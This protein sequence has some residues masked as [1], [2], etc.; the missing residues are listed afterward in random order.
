[1]SAHKIYFSSFLL[2][3]SDSGLDECQD[4][5]CTPDGCQI[6]QLGAS[7]I[8][9][10][11]TPLR[12]AVADG[13]TTAFYSGFWAA[14]LVGL[15]RDGPMQDWV[16]D[17][18][19]WKKAADDAWLE[20][21]HSREL[22]SISQNRLSER[23]PA[24]ATFCGIEIAESTSDFCG[25][26]WRAIAIGDSCV[27]HLSKSHASESEPDTIFFSHPCKKAADFSCMTSAVSN[28][29]ENPL[30]DEFAEAMLNQPILRD[31]DILLLA[32]DALCEWMIKLN[33]N[34]SPIWKTIAE[35]DN[36]E[37]F[38]RMVESARCELAPERRLKDDDVALIVIRIGDKPSEFLDDSWV[39]V[40]GPF[41]PERRESTDISNFSA[42]FTPKV[43]PNRPES[44]SI[45]Q[46]EVA[47]ET[48]VCESTRG[49]D[50]TSA[51]QC[52]FETYPPTRLY[53]NKVTALL[54]HNRIFRWL[55][56]MA[57]DDNDAKL[58]KPI[59]DTGERMLCFLDALFERFY[60]AKD[61]SRILAEKIVTYF[62][63]RSETK[64][65]RP[66]G[67]VTCKKKAKE[68]IIATDAVKAEFKSIES[69]KE[70]KS[71][72]NAGQ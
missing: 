30:P 29:E 37:A 33:E 48:E 4:A 31:G 49:G 50:N 62:R 52:L 1:M 36:Q 28:Y 15:F 57:C 55:F 18:P 19:A 56:S 71:A 16:C 63:N 24:S 10:L 26:F 69:D 8:V 3:K 17:G 65:E 20:F 35:E 53:A 60:I 2:S 12:F 27:I 5:I 34:G 58:L 13:V 61:R 7:A 32:T 70:E 46:D 21:I 68:D 72:K 23:D 41:L 6:T 11:G 38:K 47:D 42:L 66:Y 22:G 25:L 43:D 44:A 67:I 40:P 14:Q 54:G 39:Y 51:S 9:Q 64:A 59:R 45:P